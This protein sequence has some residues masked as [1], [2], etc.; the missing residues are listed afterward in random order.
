MQIKVSLKTFGPLKSQLS[1]R[2]KNLIIEVIKIIYM[3]F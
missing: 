3:I 2:I 1:E